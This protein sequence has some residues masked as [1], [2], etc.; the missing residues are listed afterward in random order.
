M[1]RMQTISL[2]VL[3][4]GN[5]GRYHAESVARRIP[6]ARLHVVADPAGEVAARLG[7]ELGCGHTKDV[8]S[9]LE[10]RAVD[11]VVIATPGPTH[12]DLIAKAA[13]AGKA[14]FCEKPIAWDLASADAALAAAD[15]AGVLLQIGF[16]RRFDP[17]YLRARELVASGAL[18]PVQ[19]MRSIT[20]DPK[21][22]NPER[23]PP[24]AIFR[25]T[26]IH[27][28]DVLCWMAGAEPVEVFAYADALVEPG[29]R[30]RGLRDT[31]T[32]QIRFASG[33]LA[34][35]DASFQAVYGYDVRAEVFGAKGMVTAE[36]RQG[37]GAVHYAPDGERRERV[38]WY[39]D[40]FGAAYTAEVAAFVDAVRG[41]RTSPVPGAEARRALAVAVAAIRSVETRQPVAV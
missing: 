9:A 16:Q 32:V 27:D 25:E 20:R 28:F 36:P 33:A 34:V 30:D 2:A 8:E 31:A 15:Q 17:A 22:T 21:L 6:G 26:L 5:I 35:A 24:W 19:L 13:R 3:G 41:G 38:F 40:L 4:A 1:I 23:V 7:I 37:S 39:L 14:V 29:L 18:G 12:A 11:A 10:D